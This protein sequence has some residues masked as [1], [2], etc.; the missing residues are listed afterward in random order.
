ML[1]LFLQSGR[2]TQSLLVF[3]FLGTFEETG[4]Y[5]VEWPSNSFLMIGLGLHVWGKNILEVLYPSHYIT[6]LHDI[7]MISTCGAKFGH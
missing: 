1:H 2:V 4:R 3:H 5:F 7:N 6:S